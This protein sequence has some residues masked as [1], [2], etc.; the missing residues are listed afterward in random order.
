MLRWL[1]LVSTLLSFS[2]P[3][4]AQAPTATIDGRVL[5]ASKAIVQGAAVRLVNV[6]T[7]LQYTSQSNANGLFA[8]LNLPPGNYRIEVSKPGFRT[9]VKPD[10]VLHVQDRFELNFEMS[11]GSILES[12]TVQG[13][14]PMVD[15]ESATVGTVV[16][17]QFAENLPLNG[18]S[19]QT[20]IQLTPGVV[21]VPSTASDSGQFSVNGQ[22]A[23][24]NYWS[25]DGV[26]ANVGISPSGSPGNGSAGAS[27]GFGVTG[28]TNS[29]VSVDAMQE[30]RIQTSTYAPEFGRTP[31]GQISIVTRSGSNQFHGTAFDYLRNDL[32]DANDW[33]AA[34][35][36]L[37][38]PEERQNDFGGTLSG[39]ALKDR[40]FFFFSYEGLRLR[41]PQVENT[42]VPSLNA[43]SAASAALQPFLNAYP[44]PNS[45]ALDNNGIS[46]F[47][48]SFSDASTL[49]AYSIR[50]DHKL[51]DKLSLFGRYN[52]SPSELKQ[53]SSQFYA[54]SI[55]NTSRI[56]L[57]T[58]TVGATWN[59][60][61]EALNDLRVNYSRTNGA[62]SIAMDG[63]G[64]AVPLSAQQVGF[65][66]SVNPAST[67]FQYSIGSLTNGF[68]ELGKT[69]RN[70]QRQLNLVDTLVLQRASHTIK[71]GV[72]YRRLSPSFEPE[73]YSQGVFFGDVPS[74]ISGTY[75]FAGVGTFLGN[76]LRFQNLGV[77]GQDTWHVSTRLTATY[78]LRWD[79]DFAPS[80]V[81]GPP[82]PAVN[83]F[84]NPTALTLASAGTPIFSTKY[85]NIAPRLGLAYSVSQR[86]RW[87]TIARAGFGV[88]YDL[89]T[90]EVG[91]QLS[92]SEWPYG[93]LKFPVDTFPLS[94]QSAAPP[95]IPSSPGSSDSIY[96]FD[97]NLK[98]PYTLQWNLAIEQS[99]GSS[100]VLTMSYI[101]A[102]GRR[103]ISTA[104][105]FSPT[106]SLGGADLVN[107]AGSSS[108]N[109]L[110]LQ[111]RRRLARGLQ[112]LSSYTW[113]HSIDTGSASSA[114]EISNRLIGALGAKANRGAS[115]FDIRQAF[116][117]GVT[118]DIPFSG[119]HRG[120]RALLRGWSIDSVVQA[121]SAPPVDLFYSRLFE[122]GI[123]SAPVRPDLVGGQPLYLR[124]SQCSVLSGG[125]CP[126][127]KGFNPA[128]FVAPPVDPNTGL[129]LREGNFGRNVLRGFGA[130]QWDLAVHRDFPLHEKLKLQF[131]AEI[132][133][134]LN[135]PNFGQ[136]VGDLSNPSFGVSTQMLGRS[137]D[138]NPGGGSFS[139]LYQI[140]G[141][142]SAQLALKVIF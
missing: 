94:P 27:F 69:G 101:G 66:E 35:E 121:R 45:D 127:G 130:V 80:S 3:L 123:F 141:P 139:S 113:G 34:N 19:F 42:T 95:V 106:P 79:V 131:R 87:Q 49:D 105:V 30:F 28:G 8:I 89:A 18:R 77:Y 37:K 20:L 31:G 52:N 116:S 2:L 67:D 50:I 6:D 48:A 64:G 36:R 53:R 71:L 104:I 43:R 21:L 24:A 32:L 134:A 56:A 62:H 140:G 85:A 58:G 97:P 59:P 38:K 63:F 22:R 60:N 128:A 129:P 12:V 47:S 25:V 96:A 99:L 70:V 111:F 9:V 86:Q 132:F 72:D 15:S 16:D 112:T 92:G 125:L 115:A 108:Y 73:A 55:I 57:Q 41:L 78:G 39:P 65:P 17:R 33:F 114:G 124:G 102:A 7:N 81:S 75:L 93:T 5:D 133:N 122:F 88:F 29:L 11:V 126:G 98:L 1:L 74:A 10:I 76:V 54:L 90:Q 46:S 138:Q 51:S 110:Q 14:A 137:L 23:S 118:Y 142:R 136:P 107:N 26:S 44:R 100:Q 91:Q 40:T 117:V 13:G 120:T 82:L 4:L 109:A 83:N 103:L 135:H 68:I 61:A 119:S 84:A